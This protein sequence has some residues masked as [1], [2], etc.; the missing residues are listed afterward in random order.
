LQGLRWVRA[1]SDDAIV[2]GCELPAAT[3]AGG[4]YA[5][6]LHD[7]VLADLILQGPPVLG[8]RLLGSACLPLG[9][10]RIDYFRPLPAG[11]PFLLT[12]DNPRTGRIDATA[13]TAD[14]TV[15]QRFSD[16]TVVTTPDLTEKFQ[17]SVRRWMA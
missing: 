1:V 4:A 13:T 12:V 3:V 9:V 15:L 7:P 11:D 5:G 2:F 10:G 8:Y 17:T 16:V 14:G 6:R